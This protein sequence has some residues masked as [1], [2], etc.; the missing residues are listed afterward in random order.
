MQLLLEPVPCCL[1]LFLSTGGRAGLGKDDGG[2]GDTDTKLCRPG[3][4]NVCR[5]WSGLCNVLHVSNDALK[6][7]QKSEHERPNS[8][9]SASASEEKSDICWMPT[10]RIKPE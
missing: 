4:C 10:Y 8:V 2:A 6:P 5:K 1:P 7:H 3:A 9:L